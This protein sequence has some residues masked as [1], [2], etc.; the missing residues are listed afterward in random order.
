MKSLWDVC[1]FWIP[2]CFFPIS[3][4]GLKWCHW[5]CTARKAEP[6]SRK[7]AL[8]LKTCWNI[9]L[10]LWWADSTKSLPFHQRQPLA[11][12]DFSYV[13]CSQLVSKDPGAFYLSAGNI[14]PLTTS[15]HTMW[16][17]SVSCFL[18]LSKIAV[19]ISVTKRSRSLC[20]LIHK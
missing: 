4:G 12:S 20:T 15:K 10:Q 17:F 6:Q 13:I 9:P 18:S 2:L 7:Y 19:I 1:I 3:K 11:S 16:S 5:T 8:F 14:D